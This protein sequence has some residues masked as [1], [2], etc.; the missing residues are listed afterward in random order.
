VE[1]RAAA[2][3]TR[4]ERRAILGLASTLLEPV[5]AFEWTLERS[6]E[7]GKEV[8]VSPRPAPVN[9]TSVDTSFALDHD[10][11][12]ETEND[13]N[14]DIL[15]PSIRQSGYTLET[16]VGDLV[17]NPFDASAD[18]IV[19]T[20]DKQSDD[21]TLSVADNG[22][23][24]D[25]VTLDQM[26]RL[27]S[28]SEHDLSTDLGAFGLGS[29]TASLSLGRRQHVITTY[30]QGRFASAAT[31]LDETIRARRFVKH[32]DEARPFELEIFGS[33]FQRWGLEV[34]ATGTVVRVTRCDNIGRA[35]YTPAVEALKRYIG[36]TYRYFIWAGKRVYVNGDLVQPIDPLERDQTEKTVLF[37]EVFE[38]TYPSGHARAGEVETVGAILVQLPDWGG[39]EANREHGYSIDRSGFYVMRNRREIVAHTTLGLYTRHSHF[40]RFRGELLFPATMDRDLG[41][42]FL[43]TAW[44]IKPTKSLSDKLEQIVRPYLRQAMRYY[45]KSLSGTKEQVP[46]D[47]AAKVIKQRSPFLRKPETQ[48]E[49][50]RSPQET[51]RRNGSTDESRRTRTPQ[52][53]RTQRA[54]A[55][56]ASFEVKDLG[57]T[58]PF[59]DAYLD[60]RKVVVI[61]NGQHPFY[62]RFML[63]HRDDRSVITG[64]DYLVYS[65]AT[66]ELRAADDDDSRFIERMR[67]DASFNLRQLL[68]T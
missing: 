17:D 46:H 4:A 14:P 26:M 48:I 19:V 60:G 42:T 16:A 38:Y 43:K 34:P 33:A 9:G 24:M 7:S 3:L 53:P 39:M 20:L 49:A 41:V 63:D 44:D 32:L 52:D 37:D 56:I 57:L 2:V 31:D 36:R 23:G 40:S 28:R 1:P 6:F 64:I 18:V 29:T 50:R 25:L 22:T 65:M 59:F 58:A 61:Y 51:G 54:L 45:N 21:W 47:E 67:E 8:P 27:G 13:P 55:D 5:A 68:S 11:R 15:L 66:A 30:E 10:F 12:F 62:Q 35:A